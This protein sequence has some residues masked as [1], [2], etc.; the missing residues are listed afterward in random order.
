LF[1]EKLVSKYLMLLSV[2]LGWDTTEPDDLS[3]EEFTILDFDSTVKR[4]IYAANLLFRCF[5]TFP[6]AVRSWYD[7]LSR[8]ESVRIIKYCTMFMSP[9]LI[10]R[11]LTRIRKSS[12]D[13]LTMRVEQTST[14]CTV[15]VQ[16]MLE[17]F[18]F[19]LQLSVPT[20]YPLKSVT[21]AGGERLGISEAKWRSW[22]LSVQTLL[23]QNLA[24]VEVL[25][26][27]KTN[28][29]KTLAGVEPCAICYCVLQP[30]DKSLPGPSC[31]TCR[32][33]FHSACLYRWFKTGG[34]ATCPMCRAL[35]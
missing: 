30:G 6:S 20:E 5:K 27:W 7:G 14:S 1:K 25:Q 19:S 10:E 13:Q 9:L 8:E 24:I 2:E 29:E 22:L 28:A 33:K 21:L 35:Y 34:Q 12:N 23:N 17:E 26:Q 31:K 3:K 11:E 4:P 16:Y 18:S 32:N 15:N